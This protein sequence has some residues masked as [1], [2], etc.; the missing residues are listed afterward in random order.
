VPDDNIVVHGEGGAEDPAKAQGKIDEFLNQGQRLSEEEKA[1]KNIKVFSKQQIREF[2]MKL[3][4]ELAGKSCSEHIKEIY[5]LR[6]Q[7][8]GLSRQAAKEIEALKAQRQQELDDLRKEFNDLIAQMKSDHEAELNRIRESA[9]AEMRDRLI[10]LEKELEMERG[11]AADLEAKLA[12]ALAEIERLNMELAALRKSLNT[13]DART[14]AEL[15]KLIAELEARIV[16]LELGLD[17]FDLEEEID[18]PALQA[19]VD[20]V[21]PRLGGS[22][23]FED[24]VKKSLADALGAA[25]KFEALQKTMYENKASI[26]VV[27]DMVKAVKDAQGASARLAVVEKATPN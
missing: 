27:V 24:A 9:A 5:Q 3:I 26:A 21:L 16:E 19:R 23:P 18:A 8:E 12:A 15:M 20:A 13:Q 22:A 14:R 11:R 10:Q 2:V 6:E 7:L 25:K 4:D 17:Y 1:K